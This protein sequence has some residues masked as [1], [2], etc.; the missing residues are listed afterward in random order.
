MKILA[1]VFSTSNCIT[2]FVLLTNSFLYFRYKMTI[3]V[4][5]GLALQIKEQVSQ[6]L[7]HRTLHA[8]DEAQNIKTTSFVSAL[9]ESQSS[10]VFQSPLGETTKRNIA[11]GTTDLRVEF[12]LPKFKQVQT[13]ILI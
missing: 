7:S 1:V 3:F 4:R 12:S 5:I 6:F 10:L 11:K 13:K 8:G 2:L 9:S